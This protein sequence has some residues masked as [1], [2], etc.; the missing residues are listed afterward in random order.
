MLQEAER[1]A[2]LGSWSL[3]VVTGE[4][5]WS[6][7]LFRIFGMEPS[8]RAPNYATQ[9]GMFSPETWELISRS[10]T[11]CVEK[12]EGYQIEF[13]IVRADGSRRWVAARGEPLEGP[14]GRVERVHGTL[15]DVTELK[16][17]R[18]ELESA[19]ARLQLAIEAARIGVWE[20]DIG[21]GRLEWDDMMRSIYGAASSGDYSVWRDALLP[22]DRAEA[23]AVVGAAVK[24][25]SR[26]FDHVFRIR[27]PDGL[28]RDVHGVGTVLRDASGNAVRM[29][30]VNRDVTELAEAERR[31]RANEVLLRQFVRHA[32]A[33]IAM[34]DDQMRYLQVS[35]RWLIDYKLGDL[36]VI[37]RSH[38]EV[39]P[40][41]PEE[42]RAIHR[43]VLAGAVDR[44]DE[45]SFPRV[46][47]GVEWLQWEVRPWTRPDGGIGG[48]IMFTQ[49]ITA[50]KN[51][52]LELIER[53]TEL[54]RS[55][56]DLEQFAYVASH[57]L[58]EPLRAVAG[59]VQLLARRYATDL[60][61]KARELIR[62]SVDGAERM[63][64][65]IH[66]LLAYSRL[67]PRAGAAVCVDSGKSLGEALR[68][69]EAIISDSGAII[70]HEDGFP[71]V[72][73]T[74]GALVQLF[75]NLVGNA[76][77]YR[78]P[79]RK[80]EIRVSVRRDGAE[81]V[82]S[83]RDNGLGIESRHFARIFV[84]FQRL[85]PRSKYEG[86]GLGLAVCKKLVEGYGGRI[87]L[88]SEPGRGSTFH[89]SI[90]AAKD[91]TLPAS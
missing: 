47:G 88:E 81:H 89:F 42:W 5:R 44:C 20:W 3:D 15:Q 34:L 39:F 37:G 58:Q 71:S 31:L 14:Q 30:G 72:R 59:C 21:T 75:Q 90:P 78:D 6:A 29:I 82:F 70:H 50:R 13:E 41:L 1:V 28:V 74:H 38:Y 52:E 79:S 53:K 18:M 40:D 32:P 7:E 33:A 80:P 36:D 55:N 45:A 91:P 61:E 4:V 77:K 83:I 64:R 67:R 48:L 86:T 76:L 8:G 35:E 51:L 73:A 57:D 84:I 46:D 27:R 2:H 9:R 68:N 65:L 22:E 54:E 85:H 62:H 17:A 25:S 56:R 60:D 63:Q 23:E 49:V 12:R 26:R 87:W 11:A 69:L 43:R 66:D 24:D 19:R 10:V 16:Q